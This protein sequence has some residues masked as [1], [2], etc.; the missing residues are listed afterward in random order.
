[1]TSEAPADVDSQLMLAFQRGDEKCFDQL[2]QKYKRPMIN[3]AHR[4]TGR[5]E[6]AEE[7][8]QEIL[9]K[10]YM[11]A[12]GY[13]VTAKFSTWLFRI[14]RNH[15]LN[16][17]RRQD[18]RYRTEPLEGTGEPVGATTP[19]QQAQANAL[20]RSLL[21]VMASLPE[22]QRIALLLSRQQ[23]M[24]YEEIAETMETS[25]SAVKSLLNRA[26]NTLVGRLAEHLENRHEL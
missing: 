2:F 21:Q 13:R 22:S 16:E 5:K 12:P 4:F 10:C 6:T 11:A 20:Q 15:C 24:S 17:V 8:A 1:M 18:Y 19:E 9:V 25:L 3:F 26:K 14:A 7:L 23:A